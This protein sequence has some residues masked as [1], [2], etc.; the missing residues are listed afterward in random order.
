MSELDEHK[1]DEQ[2]D[3]AAEDE[4]NDEVSRH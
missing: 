4:N 3:V 2:L 1:E